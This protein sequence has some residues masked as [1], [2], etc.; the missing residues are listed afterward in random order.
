MNFLDYRKH[1]KSPNN[2]KKLGDYIS[3][4]NFYKKLRTLQL[5]NIYDK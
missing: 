3:N 1:I 5:I 4:L 2:L